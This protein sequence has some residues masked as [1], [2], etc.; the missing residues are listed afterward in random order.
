M[1]LCRA[2]ALCLPTIVCA[3]MT[4]QTQPLR[5]ERFGTADSAQSVRVILGSGDTLVVSSPVILGDS[6]VGMR[7][8]SGMAP[9]SLERVA[10]PLAAIS[11][12]QMKRSDG[13]A[14]AAIALIGLVGAVAVVAASHP[15]IGLCSGH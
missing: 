15:C 5:P 13:G 11:E 14:N 1:K 9:D 10:V 12:A 8:R 6:L 4:W 2:V 3:C 7:S